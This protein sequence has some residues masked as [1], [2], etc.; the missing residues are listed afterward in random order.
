MK[1]DIGWWNKSLL[2]Y[3]R[4]SNFFEFNSDFFLFLYPDTQV[5]LHTPT[6]ATLIINLCTYSLTACS[7]VHV[8]YRT[9]VCR[10][11]PLSVCLCPSGCLL[12]EPQGTIAVWCNAPRGRTLLAAPPRGEWA[13]KPGHISCGNGVITSPISGAITARGLQKSGNRAYRHTDGQNKCTH[14]INYK[15]QI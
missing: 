14:K 7:S 8:S 13:R 12:A 6:Q 10:F 11:D 2:L 15:E 4:E 3:S 5:L 9:H 1:Y